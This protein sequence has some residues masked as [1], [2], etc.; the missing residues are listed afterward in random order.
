MIKVLFLSDTHLGLDYAFSPRVQKRRR[1][2]DIFNNYHKALEV[3]KNGKADMIIHGGDIFYRSKIPSALVTMA[4]EPLYEIA[5]KGVPVLLVPGNHERSHIPYNMLAACKGIYVFEQPETFTFHIHGR[6][7]T[8]SGFPFIKNIKINFRKAV[9]DSGFFEAVKNSDGSL[10][11]MH[12]C[13]A[14]AKVGIHNYTFTTAADVVQ[15]KDLPQS[16]L[17]VL[18]GH[19]HRAQVLQKDLRGR[20]LHASVIYPGSIERMSFAERNEKKGYVMISLGESDKGKLYVDRIRFHELYA[21]PMVRLMLDVADKT[22]SQLLEDTA[23]AL[24]GIPVDSVVQ[25]RVTGDKHYHRFPISAKQL[26]GLA[27]DMTFK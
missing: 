7:L 3:A 14:G 23:K 2:D 6:K 19:I 17:A 8:V 20:T 24:A 27:P 16:V 9:Q 18:S 21:R 1:G 22:D 10:L 13:F 4:M 5:E 12:Q 26:R 11:C 25:L 15:P